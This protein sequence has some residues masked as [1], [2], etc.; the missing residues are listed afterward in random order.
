MKI[1][2]V[3]QNN[4]DIAIVSNSGILINDVQSALDFIATVQYESSCNR[5]ILS[6][7]AVC[8]DF[9]H[10]STKLAGEIL[11]KFVNYDVKIAFVGDFSVYSS[12]SLNAFIYESNKGK[13]VFFFSDEKQAIDRLSLV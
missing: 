2:I 1:D 8:E 6:K 4:V 12:K 10:L 3:K 9:F 11:Q 13:N 5:V 7:S